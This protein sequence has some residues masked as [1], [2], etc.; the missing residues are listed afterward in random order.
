MRTLRPLLLAL[1]VAPAIALGGAHAGTAAQAR[2]TMRVDA[3]LVKAIRH[4]RVSS[5]RL[6]VVMGRRV[7]KLAPVRHA[8]LWRARRVWRRRAILVRQRFTAG[9][10]H[11]GAWMC[12][13]RYEASWRD[14]GGPYYGGLQM[15]IAFQQHYGRMLFRRKGTAN[16]WTPLEQMWIAERAYRAG[17]GFYPWPNTARSCGLI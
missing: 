3:A 10:A 15:D 11:R 17:R 2:S 12:I 8:S 4:Y 7:V 16:N 5:V 6:Q 1:L 14:D 13:H 9:P